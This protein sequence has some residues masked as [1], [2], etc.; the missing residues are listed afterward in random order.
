MTNIT[1]V[2]KKIHSFEMIQNERIFVKRASQ[3]HHGWRKVWRIFI[4]KYLFWGAKTKKISTEYQVYQSTIPPK[5]CHDNVRFIMNIK[6]LRTMLLLPFSSL[7]FPLGLIIIGPIL[8]IITR[9]NLWQVEFPKKFRLS[10]RGAHLTHVSEEA[11]H[12][13]YARMYMRAWKMKRA[14]T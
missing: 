3:L 13:Y 12:L 10:Y 5:N 11:Q 14:N 2:E 7:F 4:Y 8:D 6:K 1:V 9:H